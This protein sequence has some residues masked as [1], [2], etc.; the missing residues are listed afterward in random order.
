MHVLR[1]RLIRRLREADRHGRFHVYYPHVEGLAPG[2]CID[3]HS[4]MMAV[5]D[6]WLRIGSANLSNRS[7]GL[8]T[9]CDVAVEA[10]GRRDAAEAIR[11][12]RDRLLA[13]HL[14]ASPD[15]VAREIDRAGSIHAAIAGLGSERRGLR[16]LDDLPEW[17]DAVVNT[18]ALADLERPVSLERLVEQFG[19]TTEE[20]QPA[21][22][23][24]WKT[25]LAVVVTIAVLALAWR[26]TPLADFVTA[27]AVSGW[28]DAFAGHWWAPL[29][30]IAVY[31][32]A[33]VV[34]FP[35]PLL[36]L[37]AVVA[38][39]PWLGFVYAMAGILVAAL[40]GYYAGRLF[41]RDTVRRIAGKQLNGL[42]EAL[43]RRGLLAVTAVRL[44]PIAPFAV[45]SVVAGALRIRLRHLVLGTFLGMLPGVLAATRLRRP[46]G[47]RPAGSGRDQ[48][49]GDR[50][51]PDRTSHSR[52]RRPPVARTQ[53]T[54]RCDIGRR[55]R[56]PSRLESAL[57]QPEPAR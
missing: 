55:T 44:V 40:A 27:D 10:A 46:A 8:D 33:S 28:A 48:L 14:D 21:G 34:L 15:A 47:D 43:R 3:L 39:G 31:T 22:A 25:G 18:V 20:R 49:L 13:E 30:I 50:G 24:W 36:T 23:G 17:S 2:T 53:R 51:S 7:M 41:E 1:T 12:F 5:D 42:T 16:P 29:A 57:I 4:K 26:Y 6:E 35:R 56:P 52:A 37:A 54:A 45:E 9:E 19:P 11:R 32:P 38:F